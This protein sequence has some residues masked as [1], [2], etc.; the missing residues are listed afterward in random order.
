MSSFPCKAACPSGIVS[1]AEAS[2]LGKLLSGALQATT[3][4][5]ILVEKSHLNSLLKLFV[6]LRHVIQFS[7]AKK[8]NVLDLIKFY[9]PPNFL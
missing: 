4:M 3:D 6:I 9:V 2:A 8:I 1:G 5:Q 7:S